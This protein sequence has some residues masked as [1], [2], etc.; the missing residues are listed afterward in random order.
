LGY[1]A[2][3]TDEPTGEAALYKPT[4]MTG[5]SG[6]WSAWGKREHAVKS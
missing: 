5:E 1:K 3:M 6:D 2:Q 4:S